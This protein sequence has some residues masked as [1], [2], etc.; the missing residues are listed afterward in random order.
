MFN[1]LRAQIG[2]VVVVPLLALLCI[3]S[4]FLFES[5]REARRAADL[6]PIAEMAEHAEAALHELQKERGRTA[7]LLASDHA[8]KP[9]DLL[10]TQR[11]NS[12]AAIKALQSAATGLDL[13]NKKLETDVQAIVSTLDEVPAHRSRVDGKTA[14]GGENLKFYTGKVHALLKVV[15]AAAQANSDSRYVEQ[16][17]PFAYL[18]EATEA[19]GLERAL[20]GRLFTRVGLDGTV[21]P[22]LFLAYFDRLSV[23]KSYL[24]KF[25]KEATAGQRETYEATLSSPDVARVL[26]WREVL[27]TLL[28]TND[29]QG[30]DGSVWFGTATKRLNLIRAVSIEFLH[31]AEARAAELENAAWARVYM[32][33]LVSV[34]VAAAT[35]LV[36]LW[37]GR[38]IDRA[39]NR[40]KA[41]LLRIVDRDLD[42]E[43]PLTERRDVIGDLARAGTV[44][45][46]NARARTALEATAAQERDRELMRQ[47]Q[48]EEL[49]EK[50]RS[51][52]NG[53]TSDVDSKTGTMTDVAEKVTKIA[54]AASDAAQTAKTA[55]SSS[56]ENV[57]TVAAA[58]EEMSIAIEEIM[59]QSNRAS[60][61]I[62]KAT[63]VARET[64]QNVSSLAN[65]AQKIG[66]VVEMIRDI[67]EQTNLLALNATIEAAR[68]GDAGKGFAVVAAEVKE[69]STQ[70]AKATEEIASQINSVQGLTD[71][72]V[73]SIRQITSSIGEIMEVSGAITTAVNEQSHATREISQSITFAA[74]GTSNAVENAETVSTSIRETAVEAETVDRVSREVKQVSDA[75]ARGVEGFL[76]EMA[77]DVEERRQA[78]REAAGGE[79]VVLHSDKGSFQTY[80][81]NLSAGGAGVLPFPEAIAGLDVVM[82]RP[83][84]SRSPMRIVWASENGVGLET[85]EEQASAA[86]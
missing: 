84:G 14:S 59:N 8:S 41:N 18:V 58:A 72:A 9:R 6:L 1:S 51:L 24:D 67:A 16:I 80:L 53:V 68:A 32:L 65:A 82:E 60:D 66:T 55:S 75:M 17:V 21:D 36:S 69:L 5:F 3:A 4:F 86:A 39:L 20:G 37:Q 23:E 30:I 81:M 57:Q 61:I 62:S 26:E 19:G 29:G 38:A 76:I 31:A 52:M 34:L 33:T 74:D 56:S 43:M 63:D 2:L 10:D 85:R 35:V 45:Q 50:F 42:F 54:S 70:T 7:V 83:D 40:I 13:A 12:D 44:F 27:R 15:Y 73:E 25:L 79:K 78:T 49:I 48:M 46:D 71:G 28:Q 64:D 22:S 11:E 47:N 77:N